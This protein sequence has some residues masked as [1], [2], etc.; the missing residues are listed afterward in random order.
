MKMKFLN[1]NADKESYANLFASVLVSSEDIVKQ[2]RIGQ[3]KM[4]IH[5]IVIVR[6]TP[7][8]YYQ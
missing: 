8:N 3:G 2:E 7:P 1:S 5:A 4:Q 6:Y